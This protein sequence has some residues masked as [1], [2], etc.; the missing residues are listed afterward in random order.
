MVTLTPVM[1]TITVDQKTHHSKLFSQELIPTVISK[2]SVK[3]SLNPSQD[4][5]D[6]NIITHSL[7]LPYE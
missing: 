5:L 1:S 6:N 3:N 2:Y 4:Q 7:T